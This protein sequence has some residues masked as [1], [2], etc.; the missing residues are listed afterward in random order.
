MGSV[1]KTIKL[2]A[3]VIYFSC[4]NEEMNKKNS[5]SSIIQCTTSTFWWHTLLVYAV[6]SKCFSNLQNCV[7]DQG[8]FSMGIHTGDI[9]L[10]NYNF[11]QRTFC[12]VWTEIGSR[13][14]LAG[15]KPSK[16]HV[17]EIH[18]CSDHAQLCLT[19][20]SK[21]K[22]SHSVPPLSSPAD[23]VKNQQ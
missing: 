6:L 23:M 20:L 11:T 14:I 16:E 2:F 17:V 22:G 3:E 19:W 5:S 18:P 8:S 1:L 12:R 9:V 21:S 13:E 15:T 7:M 10:Y 4:I